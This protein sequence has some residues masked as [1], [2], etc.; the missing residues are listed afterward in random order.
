MFLTR[1]GFGSK[2]VVTG[3]ITQVDL[4]AGKVSGMIEAI[5]VLAAVDGVA[6]V[7]LNE[8]D[9]VRHQLVQRILNQ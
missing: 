6:L 2:A 5:K 3:D 7:H 4:P 1:L 8:S 9:V